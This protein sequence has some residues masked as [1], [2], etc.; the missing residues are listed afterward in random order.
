[1]PIYTSSICH[2][3]SRRR[4]PSTSASR[5]RPGYSVRLAACQLLVITTARGRDYLARGQIA[6]LTAHARVLLALPIKGLSRRHSGVSSARLQG[7]SI[8]G[9]PVRAR[10]LVFCVVWVV[11]QSR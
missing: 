1:M 10:T 9:R 2:G 8:P 7:E 6:D 3:E 11:N 5:V 4:S